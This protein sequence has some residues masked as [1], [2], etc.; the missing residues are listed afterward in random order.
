MS[1]FQQS[2]S[3]RS[4][5]RCSNL[6]QKKKNTALWIMQIKASIETG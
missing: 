1:F 2:V 6:N 3:F 5:S 4:W